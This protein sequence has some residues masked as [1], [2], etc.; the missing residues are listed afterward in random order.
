MPVIK[1]DYAGEKFSDDTIRELCEYTRTATSE[2]MNLPLEDVTV[3]ANKNQITAGAY[4]I[5]IYIQASPRH[6][7]DELIMEKILDGMKE[8]IAAFKSLHNIQ[9]PFNIAIIKM[10][11]KFA[12]EI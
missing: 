3:N 6:F 1:I 12:I 5:E 11:W 10:D 4:P 2:T 9:T 7:P 8:K